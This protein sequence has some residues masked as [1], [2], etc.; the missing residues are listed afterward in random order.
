MRAGF[1]T[2]CATFAVYLLFTGTVSWSEAITAA[3]LSVGSGAGAVLLTRVSDHHF[4]FTAQHTVAWG[5]ALASMPS[6]TV[7]TSMALAGVLLQS[8]S[9]PGRADTRPFRPGKEAEPCDRARRVTAVL[10]GSL[11]PST[12][13]VNVPLQRGEV[14]LHGIAHKPPVTDPEWI[15]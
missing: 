8:P 2:A 13:V 15:A 1:V 6:A 7:R 4:T 14:L 5:R 10:A 11:T 12:F 3:I 9:Y